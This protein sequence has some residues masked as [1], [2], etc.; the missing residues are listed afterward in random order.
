MSTRQIA[1][2]GV[3]G[4]YAIGL[5]LLLAS[6]FRSGDRL[7]V[8]NTTAVPITFNGNHRVGACSNT[9]F[10]FTGD[11]SPKDLSARLVVRA[12]GSSNAGEPLAD[13]AARLDDPLLGLF[14]LHGDARRGLHP[15]GRDVGDVGHERR[16]K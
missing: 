4:F 6:C 9:E 13:G 1:I 5:G 8:S 3:I 16:G 15:R 12:D 11:W 7:L 14:A 10:W 2:V